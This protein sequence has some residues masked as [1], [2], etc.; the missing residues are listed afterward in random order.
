V[1]ALSNKPAE[2]WQ[3]LAMMMMMTDDDDNIRFVECV[4]INGLR[5]NVNRERVVVYR[6]ADKLFQMMIMMMIMKRGF[7]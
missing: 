6:A 4:L 2:L 7:I 1:A 5:A 3:W